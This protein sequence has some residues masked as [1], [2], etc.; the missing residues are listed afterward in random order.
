[1]TYKDVTAVLDEMFIRHKRCNPYHRTVKKGWINCQCPYHKAGQEEHPSFGINLSTDTYKCFSCGKAGT[2]EG[3]AWDFEI[4]ISEICDS[5]IRKPA[6]LFTTD[7]DVEVEKVKYTT[8]KKSISELNKF[9]HFSYPN[10]FLEQRGISEETLRNWEVFYNPTNYEMCFP[11]RDQNGELM[12]IARRSLHSKRFHI[13]AGVDLPLYLGHSVNPYK[14]L[15]IAE[16][17]IDALSLRDMGLNAVGLFG[18]GS[19]NQIKC[20]IPSLPNRMIA[21]A[22]DNDEAGE[23]GSYKIYK[24][25]KDTGVMV[26]RLIYPEGCKDPND[27]LINYGRSCELTHVRAESIYFKEKRKNCSGD[28]PGCKPSI[29]DLRGHR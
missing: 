1:M 12:F 25:L 2:V 29:F 20:L 28:K 19:A 26:R 13:Q 3:L 18:L 4:D 15:W 7:E 17:P 9:A 5:S 14:P 23:S 21:L 11:V 8:W 6:I 10:E 16:G 27:I 22:L 24:S